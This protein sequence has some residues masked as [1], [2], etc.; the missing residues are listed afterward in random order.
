MTPD[1]R[2][3]VDH[4]AAVDRLEAGFDRAVERA[5][6]L[7]PIDGP[8]IDALPIEAE[9]TILAFLKR[10]EQF[11]DLIHRTLRLV[12]QAMDLGRRDFMT[13]RDVANRAEKFGVVE[14]AEDWANAV[15][16]RNAL[17]HEYPLDPHK[18][19]G[20]INAAWA[21]VPTLTSVARNIRQFVKQEG[22][23]P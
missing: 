3:L 4:L 17:S 20:Q 21:A 12:S 10:Y 5:G 9:E 19:A 14:D 8:R 22:L 16:A 7:L 13:P 15:R 2:L 23:V 18:R 1:E 11:E 6:A